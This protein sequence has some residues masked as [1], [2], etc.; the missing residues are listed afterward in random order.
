MHE[1]V[2][3]D[4]RPERVLLLLILSCV[5]MSNLGVAGMTGEAEGEKV[6]SLT[7]TWYKKV[8]IELMSDR[9]KAQRLTR[10]PTFKISS[11]GHTSY[12]LNYS[13]FNA[14]LSS[15]ETISLPW[16]PSTSRDREDKN[17]YHHCWL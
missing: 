13:T 1:F 9:R 7:A 11:K 4:K 15:A 8:V 10:S 14:N 17:E 16:R 12:R 6:T 3:Q 2:E 5:Q